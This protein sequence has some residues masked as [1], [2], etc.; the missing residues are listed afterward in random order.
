MNKISLFSS[1]IYVVSSQCFLLL[2][3]KGWEKHKDEEMVDKERDEGDSMGEYTDNI[4]CNWVV[5][6]EYIL[7]YSLTVKQECFL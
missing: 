1:I 4:T 5:V 6:I 7:Y 2:W 3:E